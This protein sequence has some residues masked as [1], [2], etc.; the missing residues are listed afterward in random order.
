VTVLWPNIREIVRT[1]ARIADIAKASP[2][3][4]DNANL[5]AEAMID[6]L[7]PGNPLLCVA[8]AGPADAITAPREAFRGNLA[9]SA[10]I[11]PSPM[12]ALTGLTQEGRA[13]ARCLKNTGP[14]FYLVVEFD[15]KRTEPE[16]LAKPKG[17]ALEGAKTVNA[18]LSSGLSSQEMCAAMGWHLTK[19]HKGKLAAVV[20]SGGKSLH[21][22]FNVKG[23]D[24]M[25]LAAWFAVARRLGADPATWTRCQLVRL[26]GGLR[27]NGQRQA[28][29]YFNPANAVTGEHKEIER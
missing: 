25:R 20:S 18:C 7:F 27:D 4:M 22:W 6:L 1:G 12:S 24:E 16:A 19:F 3:C 15:F 11:V 10:L 17:H 29:L 23:M 21:F 14:R 13:S 9:Q 5:D 8:R 28:V 26:P 2:V